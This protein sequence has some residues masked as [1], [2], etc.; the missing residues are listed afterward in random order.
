M[1]LIQNQKHR[2]KPD[3]DDGLC[4]IKTNI[5][6]R[7]IRLSRRITSMKVSGLI[8]TEINNKDRMEVGMMVKTWIRR[9]Y[10][11]LNLYTI[12][13][14][15]ITTS[16]IVICDNERS[17]KRSLLRTCYLCWYLDAEW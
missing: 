7:L 11:H 14:K 3:V 12:E 17:D 16:T 8:W 9:I 6:E 1:L 15:N 4:W 5:H 2:S 13:V 10:S